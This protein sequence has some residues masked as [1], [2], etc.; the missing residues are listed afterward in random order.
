MVGFF[1]ALT[2][3]SSSFGL[4]K[5]RTEGADE[6]D[7]SPAK[8]A[9]GPPA[10]QQGMPNGFTSHQHQPEESAQREAAA[11]GQQVGRSLQEQQQPAHAGAGGT[12][13]QQQQRPH[14]PASDQLFGSLPAYDAA[15][16]V[17]GYAQVRKTLA[18]PPAATQ[19]Q[20][21]GRGAHH[22][23]PR[24]H[25]PMVSQQPSSQRTLVSQ[26]QQQ[27]AC[28]LRCKHAYAPAQHGSASAG[29][30]RCLSTCSSS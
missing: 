30:M 26:Q 22:K 13:Q 21:A 4:G 11:G 1:Q 6:E 27:A 3:F 25:M 15:A 19:Q 23:P 29:V 24:K 16:A 9:R 12:Q 5:R 10:Q 7:G 2:N 18:Q 14:Q 20:R 8:K 28:P 17:P